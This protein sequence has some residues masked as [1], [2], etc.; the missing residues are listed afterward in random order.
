[1][2]NSILALGLLGGGWLLSRSSS[3]TAANSSGYNLPVGA[4]QNGIVPVRGSHSSLD[5]SFL[6]IQ[7]YPPGIRNNNP[8]NIKRGASNWNGKIPY[9]QSQDNTFEQF[10]SWSYG[11]RAMAYLLKNRYVGAGYDTP[12]KVIHKWAPVSDNTVQSTS[13]YVDYVAGFFWGGR[14]DRFPNTK[15]TIRVLVQAI[16]RWENARTSTRFPE[17]ITD[18][19]FETAWSIL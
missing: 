6:N 11:V 9:T 14:H 17:L 4:S 3:A 15:D 2:K 1:M 7:G 18:Q 12:Y 13:N 5:E 19:Q 8:G 10:Q 16:A